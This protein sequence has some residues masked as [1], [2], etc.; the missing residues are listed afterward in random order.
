MLVQ[1]PAQQTMLMILLLVSLM[2]FLGAGLVALHGAAPS[3]E[4]QAP[5]PRAPQPALPQA[6]AAVLPAAQA[7][8]HVPE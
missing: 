7:S 1:L 2:L 6:V 3:V 4:R 8:L 5:L